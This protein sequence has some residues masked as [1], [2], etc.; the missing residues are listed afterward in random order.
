M[1][2]NKKTLK[3]P[4]MKDDLAVMQGISPDD[5]ETKQAI[6]DLKIA[7][8]TMRESVEAAGNRRLVLALYPNSVRGHRGSFFRACHTIGDCEDRLELAVE[9]FNRE[10]PG[11]DEWR[12]DRR[13]NCER[14]AERFELAA[15]WVTIGLCVG[16]LIGLFSWGIQWH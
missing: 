1:K 14:T 6:K 15:R 5:E 2:N 10:I 8:K 12:L 13:F 16:M 3:M 7:G 11:G 9:E 4:T